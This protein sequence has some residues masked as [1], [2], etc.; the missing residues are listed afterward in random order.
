MKKNYFKYLL[1]FSSL[2][3]AID[4]G[5][6]NDGELF[7]MMPPCLYCL[8]NGGKLFLPPIRFDLFALFNILFLI[9]RMEIIY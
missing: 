4:A 7:K 9:N 2:A 6:A 1:F 3:I 5:D 8:K